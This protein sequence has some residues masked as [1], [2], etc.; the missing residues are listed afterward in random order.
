MQAEPLSRARRL[1][2]EANRDLRPEDL[3]VAQAREAMAIYA[4][5]VKL[6][7]FGVAALAR[8]VDDATQVAKTAGTSMGKAK[9]VVQ[10]GKVLGESADLSL[11][12]Q[13]GN[14]SLDQAAEIA[15][16]E[17]SAPGAAKDLLKVAAEESFHALKDKART[18]KLEAEKH[19]GLAERQHRARS[20]RSYN[21][22]LGMTHIH[23]SLEP[24]IATPI[25]ARAE[26]EAAR[27]AKQAKSDARARLAKKNGH[28][29]KEALQLEPFERHLADAY[30][31]LLSGSG[32][33][34]AKRPEL[35]V[36]VSHEV[37]TR[38]WKDIKAGEV[39][40][41][42]GVG[43]VAPQVAKEIAQD[44]FLSGLFYDGVD[45]RQLKRWSRSI[46]IEVQVA[47][48]LGEPPEFDGV[49]CIDCGN[50]FRTEF[51]HLEPRCLGGPTA[52]WNFKSR[53]W[54]C[55]QAKTKRD[56]Q[57]FRAQLNNGPAP[58]DRGPG[59]KSHRSCMAARGQPHLGVDPPDR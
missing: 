29:T 50:R 9:A 36:L 10:T 37:A 17:Q 44:A 35:V 16:A 27:I 31:T 6:G 22:A 42:P 3:T 51:D 7:E 39:C 34:R 41:I 33:G 14:V 43:P 1:L 59:Q 48:E 49:K 5:V 56:M 58:S 30:A 38:G 12:M 15:S 11:A 46:P 21:D 20:A 23:L 45:L 13:Q 24:H 32:K 52:A 4:Q 8:R 53:C 25:V 26:A 19:R 18:T 28:G 47:L 55:H 40:K 57:A 2:E 54:P